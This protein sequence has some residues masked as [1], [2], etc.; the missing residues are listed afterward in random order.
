[1]VRSPVAEVAGVQAAA[2]APSPTTVLSN[3]ARESWPVES[4]GRPT[5]LGET[6]FSLQLA[7]L[8]H[9]FPDE[10]RKKDCEQLRLSDNNDS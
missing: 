9:L 4:T 5:S 2:K 10:T 1:L 6:L 3:R 8:L 7:R